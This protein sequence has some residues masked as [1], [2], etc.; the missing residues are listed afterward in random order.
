MSKRIFDLCVAVA[1]LPF[2][3]LLLLVLAPLVRLTS[4]SLGTT[5]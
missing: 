1:A 4:E 5:R 3:A 2:A